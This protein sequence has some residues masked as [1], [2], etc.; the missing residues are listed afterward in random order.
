[1]A[2][3]LLLLF[4]FRDLKKNLLWEVEDLIFSFAEKLNAV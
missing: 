1:M 4:A 3:Q 2:E